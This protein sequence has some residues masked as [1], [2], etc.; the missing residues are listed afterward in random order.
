MLEVLVGVVLAQQFFLSL[1][2]GYTLWK[3][4]YTPWKIMRL[5]MKGLAEKMG[6][7]ERELGKRKALY[8]SDEET[9]R[10]EA[11]RVFM[12]AVNNE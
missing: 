6:S 8:I 10:R 7:Y 9:A 1:I 5:D 2:T 3:Y 11:R 4:V 12:R